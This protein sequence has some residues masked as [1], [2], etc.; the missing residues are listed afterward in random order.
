MDVRRDTGRT[1]RIRRHLLVAGVLAFV[2]LAAAALWLIN[3]PPAVSAAD[4]WAGTVLQGELLAE[5]SASGQ[6]VAPEIRAVT[7][8]SAGVVERV[9]V[10]PGAEVEPDTALI[11]MSSPELLDNLARARWKVAAARADATRQ[12]VETANEILQLEAAVATAEADYLGDRMELEAFAELE[13]D[14]VVSALEVERKRLRVE[15]LHR[16]LQSEQAR[17]A[18]F[19]EL[20]AAR[21]EATAAQLA[22]YEAEVKQLEARVVALA[23][24][25]GIRGVVQE[26]NVEE[27][28]QLSAGE[29][30]ARIV[31]PEVLIARLRVPER[32]AGELAVGMPARIEIGRNIMEGR[33][34]RIDP[35]VR[36]RRVEVDVTLPDSRPGN[37]R[38]ELTV[39]ARIEV[40]RLE[41]VAYMPRPPWAQPDSTATAFVMNGNR[42]VR[43]ELRFGSASNTEIEVLE[44]LAPGEQVIL[45]DMERWQ[46][47]ERLRIR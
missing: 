13:L 26:V 8:R 45:T 3:R 21:E 42:A 39:N 11:D 19:E 36:E 22:E 41:D 24:S 38:P 7:N 23:V 37:L 34:E 16:R 46:A 35:T 31:N 5:V 20:R 43:R 2:A 15:A 25:A 10:L 27:G 14:Q 9:R 12:R 40:E 47:H 17:L 29:A 1:T 28:Q 44:G 30:V 4:I 6:L 33:I 32:R 18:R